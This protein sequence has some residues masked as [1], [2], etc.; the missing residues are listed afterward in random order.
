MPAQDRH[1]TSVSLAMARIR[2][3]MVRGQ[4]AGYRPLQGLGD[5]RSTRTPMASWGPMM[6]K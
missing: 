3:A 4:L 2:D 6:K 1:V 5:A